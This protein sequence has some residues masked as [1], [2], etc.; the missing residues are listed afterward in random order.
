MLISVS[1]CLTLA[2]NNFHNAHSERN[3]KHNGRL[4][5]NKVI[6]KAFNGSVTV[7]VCT[8]QINRNNCL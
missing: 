7:G 2:K 4:P 1:N 8:M 5:N 6:N 3:L